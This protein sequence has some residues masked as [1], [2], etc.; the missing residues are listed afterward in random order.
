MDQIL[1]EI[2]SWS[3][4]VFVFG[5]TID[6]CNYQYF[7]IRVRYCLA[8]VSKFSIAVLPPK[9]A[10][11]IYFS[12]SFKDGDSDRTVSLKSL[13]EYFEYSVIVICPLLLV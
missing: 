12:L 6:S 11:I 4:N 9:E 10:E 13:D 3:V 2:C 5:Y 1:R 7:N 8:M